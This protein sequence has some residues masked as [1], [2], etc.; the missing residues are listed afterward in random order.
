M[1]PSLSILRDLNNDAMFHSCTCWSTNDTQNHH[2][3][4]MFHSC[5]CWLTNDTQNHHL[6]HMFHSCT[7]WLPNN[8]QNHHLPHQINNH[9][10]DNKNLVLSNHVKKT[11]L[12]KFMIVYFPPSKKLGMPGRIFMNNIYTIPAFKIY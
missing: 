9:H 7:C 4:H 8:T 5:T 11:T 10:I 2:L 1:K 3:P 6:P 12:L